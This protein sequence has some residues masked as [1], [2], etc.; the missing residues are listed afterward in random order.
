MKRTNS[1]QGLVYRLLGTALAFLVSASLVG[2]VPL[3]AAAEDVDKRLK[4]EWVGRH[5]EVTLEYTHALAELETARASHRKARQ[6][7]RLQGERRA[8]L[9][10]NL[11]AAETRYAAAQ[12][13][14]DAFPEDARRAGV[15]PGW[16]R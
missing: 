1:T 8:E 13:A 7:H 9:E 2:A 3:P 10:T 6:R 14:M 5:R 11:E 4:V 16:F 12:Q 15:P